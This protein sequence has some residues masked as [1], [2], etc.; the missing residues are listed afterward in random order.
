M[1]NF[2]EL[3]KTYLSEGIIALIQKAVDAKML[4]CD[5]RTHDA[6]DFYVEQLQALNTKI[7]DMME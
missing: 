2:T 3:E 5:P 1:E 4:V 7:C 6:I